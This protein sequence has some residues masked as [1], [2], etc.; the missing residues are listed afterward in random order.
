ML[1]MV[2]LP[3]LFTPSSSPADGGAAKISP[4]RLYLLSSLRSS[5]SWSYST[6]LSS[7]CNSSLDASDYRG[8]LRLTRPLAGAR[9]AQVRRYSPGLPRLLFQMFRRHTLPQLLPE[10]CLQDTLPVP[11]V[12]RLWTAG[13]N[14]RSRLCNPS[15]SSL[16]Q[17]KHLPS[18]CSHVKKAIWLCGHCARSSEVPDGEDTRIGASEDQQIV[19]CRSPFWVRGPNPPCTVGSRV[20]Q[21][22][23]L[24]SKQPLIATKDKLNIFG[25]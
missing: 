14:Y 16:R 4:F 12:P 22:K 23:T 15:V 18:L 5:L 8:E 9:G 13:A 20:P 10:V 6:P 11:A 24:P 19:N 7:L 1:F 21:F 17:E 2:A 3:L 25:N